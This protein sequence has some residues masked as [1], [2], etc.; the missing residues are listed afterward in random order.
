MR[1]GATVGSVAAMGMS[2]PLEVVTSAGTAAT[3]I[4]TTTILTAREA[5]VI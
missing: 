5:G 4:V 1:D 3:V 2:N